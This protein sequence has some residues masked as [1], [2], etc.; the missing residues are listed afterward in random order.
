MAS[1]LDFALQRSLAIR[2]NLQI[3]LSSL[4]I[5]EEWMDIHLDRWLEHNPMPPDMPNGQEVSYSVMLGTDLRRMWWGAWGDPRGFVPRMADYFKLCNIDKSDAAVL[6][7][8]GVALEPTSVGSW[9]A[10]WG[11]KVVTGWHFTDPHPWTQVEPAFGTHEAKFQLKKWV[12][13]HRVERIER[14][15]QAIGEGAFSELELGLAGD[16]IMEQ[17]EQASAAFAHFTGAPLDDKLRR[18][19][20]SGQPGAGLVVRIRGGKVTRV[21]VTVPALS[22]DAVE[23]LS[24]DA[25]CIVEG[26]LGRVCSAIGSGLACVAYARAGERAGVDVF[27]EPTDAKPRGDDD[28]KAPDG[29]AEP[30]N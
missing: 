6:D 22:L 18:H 15:S 10:V 16:T 4:P 13:D 12:E 14:F 5:V 17:V 21:A 7:Q 29:A 20:C 27:L 24:T 28:A 26:K 8:L 19:L 30:P 11:G 3:S 23:R 2:L 1:S 9:I 25:G